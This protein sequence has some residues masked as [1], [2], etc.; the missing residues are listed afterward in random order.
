MQY[1]TLFSISLLFIFSQLL[2]AQTTTEKDSTELPVIE[3]SNS[4]PK[5]EIAEIK[6]TGASNYEDFVLIGFSGLAVGDIINVPG[7][8]ITN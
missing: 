8:A 7:D 5:Y 6:V 1:K 3:Y 4:T 2:V